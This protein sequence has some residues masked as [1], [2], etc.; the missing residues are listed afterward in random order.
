MR[1]RHIEVF[2]EVY[3]HGSITG[4]ARA[5]NISQPSVSKALMHAESQI[6]FQLFKRVAGRLVATDEAHTL[7]GETSAIFER[8][9]QVRQ[10]ARNL[11]AGEGGH[12]RVAVVPALALNVAPA[13]VA[14]FREVN[15]NVTFALQIMHFDE[16]SRSLMTRD[17][18]LAIVFDPTE[19]PLQ[20]TFRVGS[21]Q[22]MALS[23]PGEFEPGAAGLDVNDLVG[24]AYI[25]SADTGPLSDILHAELARQNIMLNEVVSVDA[26]FTAVELVRRGGG[27]AVVDEFT[28]RASLTSGLEAHPL[29]PELP[30]GVY[31]VHLTERPLSTVARAF[32]SGLKRELRAARQV[33]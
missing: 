13:A 21:G 31:C 28:A 2:H 25:G 16:V 3:K 6:G 30:F 11:R 9:E 20:E 32:V 24:H 5:L 29:A 12:L 4:A 23:R 17:C 7:F 8:L 33:S 19:H 26:Y 15:P 27:V 22:L 1:I 10:M 14:A 18:D